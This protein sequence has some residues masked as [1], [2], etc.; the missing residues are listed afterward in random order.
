MQRVCYPSE[1]SAS[2][3]Q[4]SAVRQSQANG[5]GDTDLRDDESLP[6]FTA[7]SAPMSKLP[8][9]RRAARLV[10]AA[11]LALLGACGS[12][13]SLT[14]PVGEPGARQ[15]ARPSTPHSTAGRGASIQGP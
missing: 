15:D 5:A 3:L 13:E 2:L 14:A 6:P 7:S 4:N 8:A 12:A 10:L 9:P 1:P 11:T